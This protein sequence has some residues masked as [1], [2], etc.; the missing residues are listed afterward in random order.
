MKNTKS[1][2]EQK[3]Q[4]QFQVK[5]GVYAVLSYKPFEIGKIMNISKD[6][7]TVRYFSN[8]EQL[9]ETSELDIF[10]IDSNYYIE[11]IRVNTIS[12]FELTDKDGFSSNKIRQRCFQFG[13]MKSGQLFYLDYF[14]EN[15]TEKHFPAKTKDK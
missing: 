7:L 13:K 15:F 5:D 8:G 4:N 3:N 6:G 11:K 12:D 1:R 2:I 9:N 10:I 14:L